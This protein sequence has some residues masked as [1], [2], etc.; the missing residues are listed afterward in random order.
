VIGIIAH[1][2]SA[3]LERIAL[4]ALILAGVIGLKAVE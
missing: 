2:E 3:S 4:L 1:G